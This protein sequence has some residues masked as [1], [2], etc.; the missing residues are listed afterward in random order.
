MPVEHRRSARLEGANIARGTQSFSKI[1]GCQYCPWNRDVQQDW[2]VSIMPV[3]QRRSARLEG[4]NNA[5]ET[6]TFSKIGGCQ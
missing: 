5:R 2:R 6:Q 3:E 1:G 4:A